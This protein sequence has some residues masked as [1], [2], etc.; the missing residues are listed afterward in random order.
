MLDPIREILQEYHVE[1]FDYGKLT[2]RTYKIDTYQTSYVLKKSRLTSKSLPMWNRVYQLSAQ[3]SL[4]SVLPVYMTR[5]RESYVSYNNE[6]YYLSPWKEKGD[7][8]D[9]TDGI[10]SLY[11]TLGSIHYK[12]KQRQ[13][14]WTE[15]IE[16]K[17][18]HDKNRVKMYQDTLIKYV[19]AYEKRHYMSPFELRVCMQYRDIQ[20]VL[21]ELDNWYDCYLEDFQDEPTVYHSLCHGNLKSQHVIQHSE[22]T[23]FI[24]WEKAFIGSPVHD[25]SI[26]FFHTLSYHDNPI[27]QLATSFSVYQNKN[28]LLQKEISLLAIS[29]LQPQSYFQILERY[30][31][32]K[33]DKAQ[34][35]QLKS[36]EQC[37]RR[38]LNGLHL[39]EVLYDLRDE[40]KE[41][42]IE[43]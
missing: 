20:K 27:E 15:D 1:H 41:Q 16:Q 37:Y 8:Q 4:A 18:T 30:S 17:I 29:L 33:S 25:L 34:P 42:E 2:N 24:N 6:I 5:R 38:L 26:Y 9:Q 23:Y 19:E 40:T 3:E 7:K 11:E 10:K 35:F 39:Q 43:E 32:K 36:L 12:T 22:R 13:E 14:V 28:P 31:E 21:S